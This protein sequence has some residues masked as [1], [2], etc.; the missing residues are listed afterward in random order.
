MDAPGIGDLLSLL[1]TAP[2]IRCWVKAE[3]DTQIRKINCGRDK[4]SLR[5]DMS[6]QNRND[7]K[8]YWKN[9]ACK[10]SLDKKAPKNA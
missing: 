5:V 8:V 9:E 3:N 7:Q 1:I 6:K 10:E 4:N 2:E